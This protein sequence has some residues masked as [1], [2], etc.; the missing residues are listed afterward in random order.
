MDKYN[1]KSVSRYDAWGFVLRGSSGRLE[2]E[3]NIFE[4]LYVVMY[5]MWPLC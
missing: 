5:L 4:G 2:R 1:S 3:R